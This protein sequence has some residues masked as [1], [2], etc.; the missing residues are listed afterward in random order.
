MHDLLRQIE[1]L[2]VAAFLVS[3]LLAIG[4]TL[5]LRTITAPLRDFRLVLLAVGL[6]FI[7][8]PAF[9][10]SLTFLIPPDDSHAIGL[11]LLGGAAG[12]PFVPKTVEVAR[13]NIALAAA[14]MVLLTVGTILFLP[15]ALPLMIPGL[16]A[17]AWS[18]ARP[19][20]LFIVVP[21][22][23]GMFVKNR[24]A[25]LAARAAPVLAKIGSAALLLFFV[26][27]IAINFRLLLGIL[28]SF[29][30]VAALVY[31]VGLFGIAWLL[32]GAIPGA[33]GVLALAT[34][35]R[36][37]GAALAPA[38]SSFNDPKITVMIIVGAI[39]CVMVSFVAAKWLRRSRPASS[40]S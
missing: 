13:G 25:A 28:G 27:L 24:A 14:L 3:S 36:N 29:V 11:L 7:I 12:A 1:K 9:A 8:A 23:A 26:L 35:G 31:F 6:N 2:S 17:D 5:T 32:G 22:A 4:L 18:I 33:R 30:V 16:K 37:F 21:L 20:L 10:W 34:T 38:A 39:V 19:L 40:A 15:F